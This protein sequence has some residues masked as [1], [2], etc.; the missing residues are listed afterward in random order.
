MAQRPLLRPDDQRTRPPTRR[1]IRPRMEVALSLRDRTA[2]RAKDVNWLRWVNRANDVGEAFGVPVAERQGYFARPGPTAVR[3]AQRPLLRPN[4]QRP[5]PPT[6]PAIRPRMEI[7]FSTTRQRVV[8]REQPL[9]GASCWYLWPAIQITQSQ[10]C[11]CG[12][13][14]KRCRSNAA[15]ATF[16][17][18]DSSGRFR[19]FCRCAG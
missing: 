5:R 6:C 1:A 14:P 11:S 9:A 2:E 19:T 13:D 4:D 16:R 18:A 15:R 8:V 12:R 3:M 10:F 17:S 7:A